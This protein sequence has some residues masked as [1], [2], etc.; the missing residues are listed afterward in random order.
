M[1]A[2]IPAEPSKPV[3]IRC[4]RLLYLDKDDVTAG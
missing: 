2:M 3:I 4:V 1:A